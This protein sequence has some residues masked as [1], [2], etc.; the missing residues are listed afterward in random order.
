MKCWGSTLVLLLILFSLRA[1]PLTGMVET[2]NGKGLPRATVLLRSLDSTRII[3]YG[4]TNPL[5]RFAIPVDKIF[6]NRFLIEVRHIGYGGSIML[7]DTAI[8]G[9][10]QVPVIIMQPTATELREVVIHREMPVTIR[11][12]TVVY[13]AISFMTP[14]VKNVE[15]LLQN[16]QGFAVDPSGKLTHNGKRVEKVL[17]DGEDLAGKGYQLITKNLNA[18]FVDKVEVIN[19]FTDNRLLRSVEKSDQVGVNLKIKSKFMDK[20]SANTELGASIN[21]RYNAETN[22]ILLSK[23]MK[24][25]SF[26]SV[27]N[28]ANDV[29]A[30]V[31]AYY[32]EEGWVLP[33]GNEGMGL[34]VI[35]IGRIMRPPLTEKYTVDN[36]DLGGGTLFAWKQGRFAK[37][38][39]MVGFID[40]ANM[41]VSSSDISTFIDPQNSWSV[42]N[43]MKEKDHSRDLYVKMAIHADDQKKA[44]DNYYV[45]GLF[46]RV[47]DKFENIAT[48][49]IEDSL[50]EQIENGLLNLS[51][52]WNASR[53]L[54]NGQ[55][56]SLSAHM[57]MQRMGQDFKNRSGRYSGLFGLDSSFDSNQ[58]ELDQR[59]LRVNVEGS[60]G[61]RR[62]KVD[63]RYGMFTRTEIADYEGS[64]MIY[65]KTSDT[66]SLQASDMSA[67]FVGTFLKGSAAISK[68]GRVV[69]NMRPGIQRYALGG[70]TGVFFGFDGSLGYIHRFSAL[71]TFRAG[72]SG[73]RAAPTASMS[74]P[75]PLISGNGHVL[76][77]LAYEGPGS[78]YQ[79]QASYNV[80]SIYKQVNW[81]VNLSASLG[82]YQYNHFIV[83]RPEYTLEYLRR[84]KGSYS[85]FFI[86]QLEKYLQSISGKM[87]IKLL[88]SEIRNMISVN[89]DESSSSNK[90][91]Q[92]EVWWIS[93]FRFPV[94]LETRVRAIYSQG[95]LS[96][97]PDNRL[98]QFGW[99]QKMKWKINKSLYLSTIWNASQLSPGTYFNGVD[100]FLTHKFKKMSFSMRG[101]NLL[102]AGS[103]REINVQAYSINNNVFRLNPRYLLL[104]ASWQ[105]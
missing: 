25:F 48:G 96:G 47:R 23:K 21:K 26:L 90:S 68:Y 99:S 79:F 44:V 91:F 61:A 8:D 72:I 95:S 33:S 102:N 66:S 80:N 75:G 54:R 22:L 16:M 83:A 104:S 55:V 32:D 97:S 60:W 81:S 24:L 94:N 1:Q 42:Q 74:Y 3:A 63:Y 11:A 86:F 30:N 41:Y 6:T 57:D 78:K 40:H 51:V 89:G 85:T 62:K 65:S 52:G 70:S 58:Q 13:N 50:R 37:A 69:V 100:L 18:Q 36:S 38:R 19:D 73:N 101:H 12:D 93:G 2:A 92:S 82:P 39:A 15:D 43:E 76:G 88:G 27:N 35:D 77:G 98:W 14:E 4:L 56:F 28:V 31:G 9:W 71:K 45:E 10:K 64:T 67:F 59:L 34:G 53:A 46:K 7:I 5:G 105:W 87:G 29:A 20:L 103:T 17:V 84:S 49:A